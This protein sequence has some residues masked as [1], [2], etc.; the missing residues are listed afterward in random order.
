[1]QCHSHMPINCPGPYKAVHVGLH[2]PPHTP[3]DHEV[4]PTRGVIFHMLLMNSECRGETD[5]SSSPGRNDIYNST[6]TMVV[7]KSTYSEGT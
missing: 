3:L 6:D 1:M 2:E 5:Q 7:G 4:A